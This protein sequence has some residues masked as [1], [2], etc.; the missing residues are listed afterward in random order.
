MG[1]NYLL[2]LGFGLWFG[3]L[4]AQ[5]I[6]RQSIASGGANSQQKSGISVGQTIGQPY[7]T[8][9]VYGSDITYHPGFQQPN[10]NF[11]STSNIAN[12]LFLF[13]NPASTSTTIKSE[14]TLTNALFEV[15]DIAGKLVF[16]TK[17]SV[18]STYNLNLEGFSNGFYTVVITDEQNNLYSTKLIVSK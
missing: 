12:D 11:I 8:T 10:S 1:K 2:I 17:I 13:P 7:A 9:S 14:S 18:L 6:M 5:S 16:Q 15:R 3:V 4:N